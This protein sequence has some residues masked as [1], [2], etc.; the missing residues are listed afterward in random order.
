MKKPMTYV[1]SGV[2]GSGKTSTTKSLQGKLSADIYDIRDFD[3]RG[4]PDGGGPLWHS[5]ETRYWIDTAN[6]NAKHGKSTI[7]SGFAN[8]EDFKKIHN[9]EVDIPVKIILLHCSPETLEE[10]LQGRHSTP[11]TTAE[12]ERAAAVPLDQ[13]IKDNVS[14]S[15]VLKGIFEKENFPIVNTDGKTPNGVADL[16]LKHIK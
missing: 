4:V 11:E 10:R 6:E 8:P 16:V 5:A 14:F 1:I 13:F 12:I 15:P 7:I 9:T 2:C 3:E